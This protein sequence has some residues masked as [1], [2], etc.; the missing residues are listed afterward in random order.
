M[1]LA[2][3][4]ALEVKGAKKDG[5]WPAVEFIAALRQAEDLAKLPIGRRVVVI[6]GGM[7]AVDAAVQA[8]LLGS[9]EVTIVYPPR[10]GADG[11]LALRA[12]ARVGCGRADRV[13]RRAGEVR[14]NGAVR[15]MEFAYVAEGPEGLAETGETLR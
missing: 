6:G 1:G 3:V 8:K 5:V 12:G 13:Q 15:E 2:G 11:G 7:T 10:S 4:N 14:G 9:E